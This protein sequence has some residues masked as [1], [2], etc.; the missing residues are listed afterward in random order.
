MEQVT[1][2]NASSAEESA[3]AAEELAAQAESLKD[4]VSKLR[5]LIGGA[6]P[7][8]PELVRIKKG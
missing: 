1:Q 6:T 2:S 5:Q 4:Q 3:S 7:S 8:Q